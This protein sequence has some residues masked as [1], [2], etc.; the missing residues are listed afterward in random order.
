MAKV[1][2]STNYSK[3]E[4]TRRSKAA[5]LKISTANKV[6]ATGIKEVKKTIANMAINKKPVFMPKKKK[7]N[8]LKSNSSVKT[9]TPKQLKAM[10]AKKSKGKY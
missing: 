5:E 2:S 9:Y 3:A 8:S 6:K 10:F 4:Y 1:R 7:D